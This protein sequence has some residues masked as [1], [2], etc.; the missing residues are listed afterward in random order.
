MVQ[1]GEGLR[2]PQ[3]RRGSG[4]GRGYF[5]SH[6]DG[7][8]VA[9]RRPSAGPAA[10]GADRRGPQGPDRSRASRNLIA[11]AVAFGLVAALAACQPSASNAVELGSSP[12]GL[13]QVK[14]TISSA[15]KTHRFTVEVARTP[16]QQAL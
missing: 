13:D 9:D 16:E 3:S 4:N 15:G 11:R 7:A 1:S 2:F 8:P 14:L 5:R 6:G 12:A 10:R